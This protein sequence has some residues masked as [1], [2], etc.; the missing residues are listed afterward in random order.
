MQIR[1]PGSRTGEEEERALTDEK[2]T[3]AARQ[4]RQDEPQLLREVPLQEQ[5]V[6][7][8]AVI[9]PQTGKMK[10]LN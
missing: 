6:A 7:D 2:A 1:N 8:P 9:C 5:V 3:E 4:N 10:N